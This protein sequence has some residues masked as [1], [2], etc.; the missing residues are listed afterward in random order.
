M[1]S[2]SLP[3]LADS[4]KPNVLFLFSDD[5]R[6]DTIAALGNA[7]IITPNLDRLAKRSFVFENAYNFGGNSGAVC[8]P[9]RNM[10]M[11]GKNHFHFDNKQR[12]KGLGAT[13]PK[14]MKAAGY[15]T[16]FREK[17]GTANL[18]HIRTQFE[19]FKDVDMVKAL[20]SGYAA[21]GI[22]NDAI[23]FIKTDRDKA[24]PFF[25]YLG[26]PC[27]HD[28]R[29]SA[30]EFR[31]MYDPATLPL[32]VN[33]KPQ[34]HYDMGMMTIRDESLEG[35]PRTKETIRRTLH[36]YYSLITSMDAD[37]GRLLNTLD[38]L[39][40]T[41]D[42]IIVY[43]SDQGIAAGSHGLLGKQSLYEDVQRVPLLFSG[44]GIDQGKSDAFAY[45]FDI[46]PT[47][48]SLVGAADPQGI[49]GKNLA[50]IM[51]GKEKKVRD[52]VLLAYRETQRSVRN[53]RWKVYQ[54]P[55]IN[56]TMLFDLKNDPYEMTDLSANPEFSEVRENMMTLLKEEQQ[57]AGDTLA[58]TSK[59]P[60]TAGFT[61]PETHWTPYPGGGLAPADG[62][63]IK[64]PRPKKKARG[65]AK[66]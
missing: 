27:P 3:L 46:L 55:A 2:S 52:H 22:V 47:V 31:D 37:I 26:L 42:T 23:Q 56:R 66:K 35:W 13:F 58:L 14:S 11:T 49:D 39:G 20:A 65:K 28:P 33:Y 29:W 41:K 30:A 5:Q 61:P 45:I 4:T 53:E 50:P 17:S 15:E 18:P 43:S 7:H 54:L 25:M 34:H 60:K 64:N 12:D 32:P 51:S 21:R 36:D 1:V 38:E 8:I 44:P 9:A 16:Y 48:C 10:M 6:H 19:H 24:R 59:H 62:K 63:P 57:L 40:L